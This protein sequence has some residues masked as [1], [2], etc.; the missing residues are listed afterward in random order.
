MSKYTSKIFL[1]P[2]CTHISLDKTRPL[3]IWGP[4]TP[5]VCIL[6]ETQMISDCCRF[7]KICFCSALECGTELLELD[8]HLTSDGHV[9]VSH[10]ND[11]QRCT[12]HSKLISETLLQVWITWLIYFQSKLLLYDVI[13]NYFFRI[14]LR[15]NSK[16]TSHSSLVCTR[17]WTCKT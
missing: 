6:F 14:C 12:G 17:L 8:C 11:L 1:K 5:L 4:A 13:Q 16:W 3:T 7:S 2:Q 15:I 9:V 10:D